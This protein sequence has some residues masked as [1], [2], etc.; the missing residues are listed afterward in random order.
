MINN[1]SFNSSEV[2]CKGCLF[3]CTASLLHF[4]GSA[5]ALSGAAN[6]IKLQM[7]PMPL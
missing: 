1:K 5:Q 4:C 3:I 6:T 2:V 7:S